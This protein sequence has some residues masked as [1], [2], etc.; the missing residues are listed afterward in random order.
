[1][2][3]NVGKIVKNGVCFAISGVCISIVLPHLCSFLGFGG[4]F[5]SK[6]VETQTAAWCSTFFGT[7]GA[8]QSLVIQIVDNIPFLKSGV[9]ETK[10]AVIPPPMIP[11]S[12]NKQISMEMA[13]QEKLDSNIAP[14]NNIANINHDGALKR[15][16]LLLQK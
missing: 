5:V 10:L 9:D 11:L 2:G 8:M 12:H 1:M 14:N 6:V 7:I 13:K 4:D 16:E 15:Q 3:V